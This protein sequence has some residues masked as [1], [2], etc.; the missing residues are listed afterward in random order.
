[1]AV[2]RL[3]QFFNFEHEIIEQTV[4]AILSLPRLHVSLSKHFHDCNMDAKFLK[5]ERILTDPEKLTNKKYFFHWLARTVTWGLR[6]SPA[7]D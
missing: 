5:I 1:M 4:T 6:A 2:Y 3:L 7:L